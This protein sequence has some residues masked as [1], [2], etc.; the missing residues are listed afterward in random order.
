MGTLLPRAEFPQDILDQL[1]LLLQPPQLFYQGTD[2]LLIHFFPGG[3]PM[4]TCLWESHGIP[5]NGLWEPHG[6]T[7]TGSRP[8]IPWVTRKACGPLVWA[9]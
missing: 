3:R 1:E 8:K 9:V 2:L 6:I 7:G 5:A 4:V